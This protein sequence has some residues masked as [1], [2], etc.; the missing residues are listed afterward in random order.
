MKKILLLLFCFALLMENCKKATITT[1]DNSNG[2][3]GYTPRLHIV[4]Y[5]S[6]Y[7]FMDKNGKIV[8]T[9]SFNYVFDFRFGMAAYAQV[10][11][12]DTTYGFI[13]DKGEKI[14]PPIYYNCGDFSKEGLALVMNKFGKYGYVNKEGILKISCQYDNAKDFH[15]GLALVFINGKCGFI[16][17]SGNFAISP[18]YLD[19]DYF[20]EGYIFVE[21]GNYKWGLIDIKGNTKINYIYDYVRLYFTENLAAVYKLTDSQWG[22]IKS[23]GNYQIKPQFD[24]AYPFFENLAAISI[25]NKYGYIDKN[26]KIVINPEYEATYDFSEGLAAVVKGGLFGFIDK[27]GKS[28]IA[29]QYSYA[30]DFSDGLAQIYLNDSLNFKY[31]DKNNKT[32]WQSDLSKSNNK[33]ASL[34]KKITSSER[35]QARLLKGD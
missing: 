21:D 20:N 4:E 33:S 34:R 17:I 2:F 23:D 16:D 12:N 26:G 29:P 7:G 18:N 10:N 22:Y 35:L 30:G 28:I 15:D 25:G 32:V 14:I 13:N 1:D 6:G 8:I 11:L 27:T 3:W 31:I 5:S 24:D 9:P 19:A